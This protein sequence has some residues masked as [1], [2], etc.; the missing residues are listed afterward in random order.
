MLEAVQNEAD[1]ALVRANVSRRDIRAD[2][3]LATAFIALCLWC[4]NGFFNVNM[5]PRVGLAHSIATR[6]AVDI[7]E[8]AYETF[9]KA[10]WRGHF[11]C[12]KAPGISLLC[13]P[14]VFVAER[15]SDLAHRP[16]ALVTP[17]GHTTLRYV[18]DCYA[19][20]LSTT[21]AISAALLVVF[22][23]TLVAAGVRPST[24]AATTFGL[25]FGSPIFI[26]STTVFGHATSASLLFLSFAL[27]WR[28]QAFGARRCIAAGLMLGVATI[29]EFTAAPPAALIALFISTRDDGRGR[30]VAKRLAWI[31]VGAAPAAIALLIYNQVAFG[32]A[33]HIGY[34]ST[35]GFPGMKRGFFGISLPSGAAL[36][37]ITFG[38]YRGIL[39]LTPVLAAGF[40]GTALL[41]RRQRW[42]SV[43]AVILAIAIYYLL[44]NA[45]YFY[46]DGGGALGPR[47]IT[48]V[49]PFLMFGLGVWAD[50]L[51]AGWR[52]PVLA[53]GVV[54]VAV[55]L[56]STSVMLI[57][58][59]SGR[60]ML[61]A[62]VWPALIAGHSQLMA[63][64][65]GVPVPVLVGVPLA[66]AA[67]AAIL[68]HRALR[69]SVDDRP[70]AAMISPPQRARPAGR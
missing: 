48:P 37:G 43:A 57:V 7:D 15:A 47:H 27:G 28:R 24:A 40:A 42:R 18:L 50:G 46:W 3:I 56:V 53:L 33:T 31:V 26:W 38:P 17:D 60:P 58:P 69:S 34:S 11:Y 5:L 51:R 19:C 36:W 29:V 35:Q 39:W 49:V 8:I 14:A 52:P 23:R 54:G 55:V 13:T 6:G 64:R 20:L 66:G 21:I 32:S 61:T 41:L 25:G 12:D 67:L 68:L 45:S 4:A 63:A 10:E 1:P 70:N 44:V 65:F 16:A 59:R 30:D 2:A 9:D 62:H 22:R